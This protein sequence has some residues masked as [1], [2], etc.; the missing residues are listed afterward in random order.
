MEAV[1]KSSKMV[2]PQIQ[3]LL[4]FFGVPQ[5]SVLGPILFLISI[6]DL[7]NN[8]KS[9][10]CLLADDCALYRNIHYL[11]DCLIL[12]EDLGALEGRLANEV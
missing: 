8:I 7:P 11:Q 1:N 9:S 6:N 12:Q 2:K 4:C 10:V 5:G 3:S